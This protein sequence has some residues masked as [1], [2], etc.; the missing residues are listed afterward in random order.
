MDR[1]TPVDTAPMDCWNRT[2]VWGREQP[3]CPRLQD[4]HHCR[5]CLVYIRA[6]RRKLDQPVP[7][8]YDMDWAELWMNRRQQEREKIQ[9]SPQRLLVFHLHDEYFALPVHQLCQVLPAREP[10]PLPHRDSRVLRGVIHIQGSLHPH[11]SLCGLLGLRP[12][13]LREKER[14]TRLLHVR[15]C[16]KHSLV[17]AVSDIVGIIEGNM[18]MLRPLPDSM[19]AVQRKLSQGV[20]IIDDEHGSRQI[21]VLDTDAWD[22]LAEQLR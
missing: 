17:F 10:S 15:C 22:G 2:G 5:N 20:L 4:V 6:G 16:G 7:E 21:C 14:G 13:E 9:A 12:L 3:R 1:E 11:I 18:D 8:Q 19:P